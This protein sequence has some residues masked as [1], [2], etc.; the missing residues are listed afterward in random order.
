MGVRLTFVGHATWLVEGSKTVLIDPFITSNPQAQAAG[1]TVEDLLPRVDLV[2]ITHGH[3]DHIENA[4]D[5]GRAG[6]PV[7][8]LFEV[9]QY[10]SA[11]G[12][13]N[14]VGCNIGGWFEVEGVG[15]VFTP[16]VHS[17]ALIKENGEP[18][19]LGN[20]AGVVLEL[21]GV[22]VY[23]T[24]DTGLFGDM[25]LVGE[26]YSPDVMLVP[27]GSLFTMGIPEAVKA[28]ELVRPKVAIPMHYNTWPPIA[29]NPEEFKAAVEAAGLPTQVVIVNP[30]ETVEISA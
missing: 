4:L 17:S 3:F 20:P 22:R 8:G 9:A 11:N 10:L 25:A 2:V 13:T 14:T 27:I 1:F 6:V 16:A 30:G 21:D 24:G 7:V 15:M 19:Y 26:L 5:F 18:I 29:Q 23:H 28:V 12:A